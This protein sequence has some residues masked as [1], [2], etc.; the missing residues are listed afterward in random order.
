M[1]FV[2]RDDDWDPLLLALDERTAIDDHDADVVVVDYMLPPAICAAVSLDRRVVALVHTLY[3]ALL[4]DDLGKATT[5]ATSATIKIAT[6]IHVR[7][8]C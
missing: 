4:V 7:F 3:G 8:I 2:A 1:S 5:R 6:R